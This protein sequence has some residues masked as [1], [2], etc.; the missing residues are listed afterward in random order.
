[1]TDF[2]FYIDGFMLYCTSKN[3]SRKTL[4]SYEQSLKLL[5]IYMNNE[6]GIE[7]VKKIQTNHIRHYIKYLQERGKYTIS[8]SPEKERYN[9]PTARTDYNKKVTTTTIA[10]YIRNIKVFFNWLYSEKEI[11]RN[12]VEKIEK[13]KVERKVKETIELQEM[14]KL[15]EIFDTTTYHGYRNIII[16]KL[17]FDTG[18]RVGECLR[19]K[20]VDF[21]FIHY[22]ILI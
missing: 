15:F 1:M 8:V 18:M 20:P 14:K 17:L 11:S 4:R 5:A 9:N 12:P 3:L 19:L 21:D 16:T 10:N 7:E 6:F 13:L 2:E 22:S